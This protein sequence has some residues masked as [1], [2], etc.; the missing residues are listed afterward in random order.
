LEGAY[1]STESLQFIINGRER[2]LYMK[3]LLL[4]CPVNEYSGKI[5][6]WD[7]YIKF[8]AFAIS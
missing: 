6:E 4:I 3:I 2:K 5:L 1:A 7:Y 8:Y